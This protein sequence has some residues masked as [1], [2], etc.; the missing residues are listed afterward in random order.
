MKKILG[1]VVMLG[2]FALPLYASDNS[3]DNITIPNIFTSGSTISSS[4][5]NENFNAVKV[6]VDNISKRS[7]ALIFNQSDFGAV[8][9]E[10]MG[11]E[12]LLE[13]ECKQF[14]PEGSTVCDAGM[15]SG[16][17]F[18]KNSSYWVFNT[19]GTSTKYLD[20]NFARAIACRNLVFK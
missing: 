18:D 1:L 3:S 13:N 16:C 14:K 8:N 6:A 9:C 5:M 4:Q 20:E 7:S 12:D 17:W 2:F 19:C 11:L 10:L 15:P